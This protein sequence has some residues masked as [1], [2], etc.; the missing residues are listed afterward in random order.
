MPADIDC[1]IDELLEAATYSPIGANDVARRRIDNLMSAILAPLRQ[2]DEAVRRAASARFLADTL[3]SAGP[4]PRRIT[5]ACSSADDDR[6]DIH[7]A[8]L[9]EIGNLCR[10]AVLIGRRPDRKLPGAPMPKADV[11]ARSLIE[12]A[13]A[14]QAEAHLVGMEL[15]SILVEIRAW[16]EHRA[17]RAR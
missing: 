3:Y 1:L 16:C 6:E 12:R 13:D 10:R 8:M 9:A 5:M 15:R 4:S 14:A 2:D 7:S 17:A 11:A